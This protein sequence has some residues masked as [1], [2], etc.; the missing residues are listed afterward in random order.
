MRNE[1]NLFLFAIITAFIISCS[2]LITNGGSLTGTTKKWVEYELMPSNI[3]YNGEPFFVRNL[4]DGST[5]SVFYNSKVQENSGF[6]YNLL[7]QDLGWYKNDGKWSSPP[8]TPGPKASRL[9]VN[10]KR[11]VAVHLDSEKK[12]YSFNVRIT[13]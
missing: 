12:H 11:R 8:D 4:M 6:F 3:T 5:L 13:K 2:P 1:K 10:P 9:Y 7:W